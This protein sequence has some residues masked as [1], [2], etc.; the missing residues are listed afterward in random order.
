[1]RTPRRVFLGRARHGRTSGGSIG[2]ASLARALAPSVSVPRAGRHSMDNPAASP[3]PRP[4]VPARRQGAAEGEDGKAREVPIKDTRPWLPDP[5]LSVSLLSARSPRGSPAPTGPRR[6]RPGPAQTHE[7]TPPL[8][9]SSSPS[10][11][12][13]PR[14]RLPLTSLSFPGP[15]GGERPPARLGLLRRGRTSQRGTR[16]HCLD[17]PPPDKKRGSGGEVF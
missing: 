8:S 10:S 17:A 3:V 11:R 15:A 1:M 5:V 16:P 4:R 2:P 9:S 14:L 13:A 7:P 12:E 6:R